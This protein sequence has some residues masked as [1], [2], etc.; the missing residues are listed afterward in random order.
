MLEAKPFATNILTPSKDNEPLLYHCVPCAL[1][2]LA[3]K[4][5]APNPP[6]ART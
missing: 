1:E 3:P 4:P 2:P 5:E 6:K